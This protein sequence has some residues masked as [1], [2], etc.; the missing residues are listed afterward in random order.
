MRHGELLVGFRHCPAGSSYGPAVFG[1]AVLLQ[2]RGARKCRLLAPD[3]FPGA[4][5][6]YRAGALYERLALTGLLKLKTCAKRKFHISN[7][8]SKFDFNDPR[9]SGVARIS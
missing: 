6:L 2:W 8:I 3:E 5:R 4:A 7:C 1:H 9:A